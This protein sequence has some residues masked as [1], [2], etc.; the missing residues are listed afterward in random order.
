MA[1]RAGPLFLRTALL[2]QTCTGSCRSCARCGMRTS[3]NST[4]FG[5]C[6]S[7][8]RRRPCRCRRRWRKCGPTMKRQCARRSAA[9]RTPAASGIAR[10][11]AWRSASGSWR[12]SSATPTRRAGRRAACAA[13]WWAAAW[14]ST[15]RRSWPTW[16]P[17]RTSLSSTWPAR[18]WTRTPWART[19]RPSCRSTSS[20]TRPRPPPSSPPARRSTTT[21][22]SLSSRPTPSSWSTWT[23]SPWWWSSTAPRAGTL[24]QSAPL[25]SSC[26]SAWTTSAWALPSAAT[27]SIT[28]PMSLVQAAA[29]WEGC[30][31]APAC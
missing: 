10:W 14:R 25:A 19:R 9:W 23:P 24:R 1:V 7:V 16:R 22:S 4:R 21:P 28:T 27:D 2:A 13:P 11:S 18:R 29:T 31:G 8:R 30:G 26:S 17:T 6:W 3:G 12:R 15:W 5:S 20:S